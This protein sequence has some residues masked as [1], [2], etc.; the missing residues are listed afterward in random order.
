LYLR[1]INA[2]S[3]NAQG[4]ALN[5]DLVATNLDFLR[6]EYLF[7]STP[8]PSNNSQCTI[9]GVTSGIILTGELV[10]PENYHGRTVTWG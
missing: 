6:P 4:E 5:G 7:T 3:F 9:I 10:I 1:L 8:N 2:T